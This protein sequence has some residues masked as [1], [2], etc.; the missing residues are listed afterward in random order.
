[1][2]GGKWKWWVQKLVCGLVVLASWFMSGVVGVRWG[3]HVRHL[4]GDWAG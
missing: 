4:C 2:L 1:V 3:S